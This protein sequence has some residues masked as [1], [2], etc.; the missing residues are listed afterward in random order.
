M[1]SSHLLKEK[2][3][4]LLKKQKNKRKEG[5]GD[6]KIKKSPKNE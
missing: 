1:F 4:S 3:I 5:G 2:M 6:I